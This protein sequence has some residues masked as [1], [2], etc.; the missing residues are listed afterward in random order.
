MKKFFLLI[1]LLTL[2]TTFSFSA[3]IQENLFSNASK[4][5][6]KVNK[7]IKD[8]ISFNLV[9]INPSPTM[10]QESDDWKSNVYNNGNMRMKVYVQIENYY[11]ENLSEEKIK[12][13]V[14]NNLKIYDDPNSEIELKDWTSH[15]GDPGPY[16]HD[17]VYSDAKESNEAILGERSVRNNPIYNIPVYFTVPKSFT[18][19]EKNIFSK[20]EGKSPNINYYIKCIRNNLSLTTDNFHFDYD[21]EYTKGRGTLISLTYKNLPYQNH[22]L[23]SVPET[24]GISFG[25]YINNNTSL[26]TYF[27]GKWYAGGIMKINAGKAV[28]IPGLIFTHS[29]YDY[30][31]VPGC[32]SSDLYAKTCNN[33]PNDLKINHYYR[34]TASAYNA[35]ND[36][37][38]Q[39]IQQ[40]ADKGGLVF[41][42]VYGG[43]I[44]HGNETLRL[45]YGVYH[46]GCYR[47]EI[48]SDNVQI[49]THNFVD[50]FG[51]NINVEI[52]WNAGDNAHFWSISKINSINGINQ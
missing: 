39:E 48:G 47:K 21:N 16:L 42:R 23:Y 32:Q 52:N 26:W 2:L 13:Y 24:Y 30:G 5:H 31:D 17:I 18:A 11:P 40:V 35:P 9:S 25:N 28:S 14:Q 22:K 34:V 44:G 19:S 10:N 3:P 12:N 29:Q 6:N 51:N 36:F 37:T 46:D 38:L 1:N 33:E 45:S 41:F 43:N 15:Q 8:S 7:S 20:I 4:R 49:N 50:N 27:V